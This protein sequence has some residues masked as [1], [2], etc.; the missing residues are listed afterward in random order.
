M[1][2]NLYNEIELIQKYTIKHVSLQ[3][4]NNTTEK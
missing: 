4:Y 2:K 1:V 3:L